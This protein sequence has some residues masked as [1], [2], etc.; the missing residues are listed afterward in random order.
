MLRC[1]H[2]YISLQPLHCTKSLNTVNWTLHYIA[3][4]WRGLNTTNWTKVHFLFLTS[5]FHCFL[6]S[7]QSV[8]HIFGNS[9]FIIW[10]NIIQWK[11]HMLHEFTQ[12]LNFSNRNFR[13]T[14]LKGG[15]GYKSVAT[16]C[17]ISPRGLFA[18][19]Q[20][21]IVRVSRCNYMGCKFSPHP[22]AAM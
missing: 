13:H 4:D 8:C 9:P 22:R 12:R 16:W 3:L 21:R 10:C 11:S 2:C 19:P 15:G 18:S 17:V 1:L 6:Q 5:A 20:T 7:W 14:G